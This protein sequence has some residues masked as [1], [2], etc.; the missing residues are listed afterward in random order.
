MAGEPRV[1]IVDDDPSARRGLTR[2]IRAAGM[3][4]ESFSS[5][6]DLLASGLCDGPGCMVLDV[7]MP[8]MSGPEL[9]EELRQAECGMPI[10]FVS[11]HG[12]VPITAEAM[13]KGAVDFLTKPVD[14]DDLLAAVR[15]SLARDA[16]TRAKRAEVGSIQSRLETLTPR[17]HDVLTHVI[18]GLLNK[19]IAAE[20]GVSE[21]TVKSHRG[22]VMQKFGV[23]SVAE[24][25]RLCEQAGVAPVR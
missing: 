11:G 8:Q 19:Q 17:E 22:R 25:V 4:A 6:V 9:Q 15:A 21:D 18:A 2:L 5:A 16:E 7:R 14:R 10:I 3:E 23:V 1:L 12:D 20:L 13:K 24:L